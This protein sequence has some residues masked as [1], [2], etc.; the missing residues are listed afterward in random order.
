MIR[1]YLPK[2][3]ALF[4]LLAVNN[5]FA[6][7]IESTMNKVKDLKN[8]PKQ[9][10]DAGIKVSG[11]ISSNTT[12]YDAKVLENRRI[13]FESILSG[14]MTFDFFG[15]VKMPFTFSFNSQNISFAH[16]FDQKYRFQQPFNRFQFKPSYK[17][18][19]LL[20]GVNTMTFSPLTLNG[21]RF[22]GLGIQ[23]KPKKKPFY[24]NFMLGALQKAIRPDSTL[25]TPNNRPSYRRNGV[26]LQ[27]GFK[28]KQQNFE[29]IFLH[30]N[31]VYSSNI[32]SVHVLDN[33]Q[34]YPQK[35]VVFALKG[36]SPIGK[37]ITINAEWANSAITQDTRTSIENNTTTSYRYLGLLP[38]NAST[39]NRNAIKTGIIYKGKTMNLGL[40]YNRVDPDYKTLGAYYFTN[41]IENIAA[42]IT[43]QLLDGKISL[44]GKIG[45]QRDN[46]NKFKSQ[47]AKQWVGN[48]AVTY[49]PSKA[50]NAQ[51][52]YSNF[53]NFTNMR[54]ELE[55]LTALVPYNA[56]DTLNYRQVNQNLQGSM[57][58]IFNPDNKELKK[59]LMMNA[60]FQ[61][62]NS[63]QS[64]Q[65]TSS[66]VATL[67]VQ[68][69]YDDKKKKTA[70][71]TGATVTR[72]DFVIANDWL[73]GP[74]LNYSK[75]FLEN[76][77]KSQVNITY[78]NS[79]KSTKETSQIVNARVGVNYTLA[80][81]HNFAL[82]ILFMNRK[83][84][85]IRPID[86]DFWD[87]TGTLSYS[88]GFSSKIFN[89]SKSK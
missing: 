69:S 88:Y 77:L 53:T 61:V 87:F 82:S 25:N 6:Q 70:F 83:V 76:S 33:L 27:V 16:P 22:E 85:E 50:F 58:K 81:K 73:L 64:N 80:K 60:L 86:K 66:N 9:L 45:R 30:T 71:G 55:Y 79:F 7:D 21:H 59:S 43:T 29:I 1:T 65:N 8:V 47:T 41:D 2:T 72:N 23:F 5:L 15:K 56:L 63:L 14:N 51:L 10:L 36:A 11:N 44:M 19:T 28:R 18:L 24:G 34:I 54:T 12:Y 67:N 48:M 35:N 20:F 4:F 62:S 46:L 78:L 26:G 32:S 13:P 84:K 3:I 74:S 17:G 52:N 38:V 57:M 37:K 68:Y 75:S 49:N 31:D 42:S 89:P 40:D 39:I